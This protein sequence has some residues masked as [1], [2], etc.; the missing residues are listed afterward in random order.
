M[1]R[2]GNGDDSG[3]SPVRSLT[4][5]LGRLVRAVAVTAVLGAWIAF[6]SAIPYH[7][8]VQRAFVSVAVTAGFFVLPAVGYLLR[9]VSEQL[10]ATTTDDSV[11]EPTG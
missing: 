9:D 10:D 1:P 11:N 8:V 2:A 7:H 6:W 4:A 3:R 5:Y